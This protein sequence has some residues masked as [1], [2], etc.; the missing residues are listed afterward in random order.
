MLIIISDLH[1]GDNTCAK[2]VSAD[3]FRIFR[4]RLG[5]MILTASV[6]DDG[7]YRPI[8]ELDLLLLGDIFEIIHSTRWL[9]EKPGEPGYARPWSDPNQPELPAKLLQITRS[10]LATNAQS[11]AILRQLASGEAIV[12]PPA[13]MRGNPAMDVGGRIPVKANIHYMVGNHDWMFHLPGEPYNQI[14]QEVI[15]ALGLQNEPTPF[16]HDPHESNKLMALFDKYRIFARHGDHFDKFNFNRQQGRNASTLGDALA[17]DLLNRSARGAATHWR[18]T[19]RKLL[20]TSARDHQ[21]PPQRGALYGSAA[22]C[23]STAATP[24]FRP[25]SKPSGTNWPKNS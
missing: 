25:R 8:E 20:Q 1:L 14:R 4:D 2:T 23:A 6:R 15:E 13:D 12:L 16:P 10:I 9:D 21:H 3:A 17:I 24:A 19:A 22:R 11:F 7:R 5:Q 18:C